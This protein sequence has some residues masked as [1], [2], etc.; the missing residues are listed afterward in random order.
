MLVLCP[1]K[2]RVSC[3]F[4]HLQATA[5][6]FA[7]FRHLRIPEESLKNQPFALT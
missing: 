5:A 2:S 7:P 4:L 1:E 6:D 3:S